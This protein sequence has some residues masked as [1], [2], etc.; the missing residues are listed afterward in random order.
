[1][2]RI[3][4]AAAEKIRFGCRQIIYRVMHNE[5]FLVIRLFGLTGCKPSGS[6]QAGFDLQLEYVREG[7]KNGRRGINPQRGGVEQEEEGC[8]WRQ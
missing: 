2:S 5:S 4:G 3:G 7:Q 6:E 8:R 1:M